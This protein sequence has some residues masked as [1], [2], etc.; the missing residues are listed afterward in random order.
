[1]RWMRRAVLGLLLLVL[2]LGPQ[3][4]VTLDPIQALA[5]GHRFSLEGWVVAN[6]PGKWVRRLEAVWTGSPLTAKEGRAALDRFMSAAREEENLQAR[7]NQ[8]AALDSQGGPGISQEATDLQARVRRLRAEQKRLR[9]RAEEYLESV[10][11][12]VL[13]EQG[14]GWKWGPFSFLFPP[15]DF[16][17]DRLPRILLVSPRQRIQLV[18]TVLLDPTLTI[19]EM[20]H[21]EDQ[22]IQQRGMSALVEGLGGMA[23]YPAIVSQGTD[24]RTSLQ[25]ATHEWVHQYLFFHPLGL[26]YWRDPDTT[27]LNETVADMAGRE[28]GDM[29]FQDLGGVVPPQG[30]PLPPEEGV[31]S[32]NREMRATRLHVDEL[33][34]QGKVDEAEAYMEERRRFF[35]EHGYYI[36]KLNQA[37][38]AFYGTYADSPASVSPIAGQL[39][40]LR[41][42][43]ASIGEFIR[44]VA[45]FGSYQDFLRR[46]AAQQPSA[47]PGRG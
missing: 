19:P 21:L 18:D 33:L 29:A 13:L 7:L 1:M 41:G 40:E 8:L 16:R 28:M 34:V 10:I 5:S 9:G 12:T 11:S 22:V 14:F 30:K 35:V 24:L 46:L 6:F 2:L 45:R 23:A 39:R 26:G 27:S 15:V 38:F 43:T 36:R 37:Y 32:F 42:R 4:A 17:F 31:F 25:T 47:A 3:D 20:E 44:L